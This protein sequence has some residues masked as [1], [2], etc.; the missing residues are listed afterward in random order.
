M[1]ERAGKRGYVRARGR[2]RVLRRRPCREHRWL[3]AMPLVLRSSEESPS[4][5]G[6]TGAGAGLDARAFVVDPCGTKP[7]VAEDE[8]GSGRC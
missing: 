4:K 3:S 8:A 5:L 7:A 1:I 6:V 2:L